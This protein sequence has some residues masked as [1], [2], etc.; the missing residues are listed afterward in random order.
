MQTIDITPDTSMIEGLR[1]QNIQWRHLLGELIDNAFDADASRVDIEFEGKILKVRDDG[2]GCSDMSKF[3]VY[4]GRKQR[5]TARLGRYGVGCKDACLNIADHV[6]IQSVCDG[7]L[8]TIQCDWRVLSKSGQWKI[9]APDE[10]PT[11]EPSGTLI[12]MFPVQPGAVR[13]VGHLLKAL[14]LQYTPA[15]RSGRQLRIKYKG[16]LHHVQEY[17]LPQ[18]EHQKTLDLNVGGKIARVTVGLIPD[19]QSWEQTG[20]YI[21]HHYRVI[22]SGK[23]Q[24]HSEP[25]PGLFGW[26]ELVSGWDLAKNKDSIADKDARRLREEICSH[27]S[28]AIEAAVK[29]S[30][31]IV[32]SNVAKDLNWALE[33]LAATSRHG[34]NRKARRPG[35]AGNVGTVLPKRTG[36]RHTRAAISQPGETFYEGDRSGKKSPLSGLK[37]AF[38]PMGVDGPAAVCNGSI[39]YL[40]V[41]I[42]FL[43]RERNNRISVITHA[44]YAVSA[45]LAT[46][47]R[48]LLP[49]MFD[50]EG[51]GVFESITRAAA[52]LM[53]QLRIEDDHT[54]ASAV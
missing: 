48:G 31:K 26:V 10:T 11:T 9:E 1:R 37:V 47:N 33:E 17:T 4:G 50:G 23:M 19:G 12:Q 44:I 42:P 34:P 52:H 27:F 8:R 41:D 29:R 20:I 14:S 16:K 30:T 28:E 21:A 46:N 38:S 24:L 2:A 13:D 15:I 5:T 35:I 40:N 18:L 32:F 54:T 6:A 43:A 22:S 36:Q 7:V 49:M 53:T 39:V 45:F 25:T 51:E 3:V